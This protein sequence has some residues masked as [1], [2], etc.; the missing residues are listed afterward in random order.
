MNQELRCRTCGALL[1]SVRV[2]STQTFMSACHKEEVAIPFLDNRVEVEQPD[3]GRS[4]EVACYECGQVH[5][6]YSRVDIPGYIIRRKR[7][8]EDKE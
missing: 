2:V 5:T 7:A 8:K 3:F 4:V 1:C 6:I